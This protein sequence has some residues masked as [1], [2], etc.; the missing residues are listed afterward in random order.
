MYSH[1]K[2]RLSL[3]K[4]VTGQFLQSV[5]PNLFHLTFQDVLY[6]MHPYFRRRDW[7]YVIL[8]V[9]AQKFSMIVLKLGTI[10][11]QSTRTEKLY[12]RHRQIY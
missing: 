9:E 8:W 5:Y 7:V 3:L 4:V 12:I 2:D 10:V 11:K 6:I 1:T